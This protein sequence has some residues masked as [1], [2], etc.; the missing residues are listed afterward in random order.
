MVWHIFRKDWKLLWIFVVAVALLHWISAVIRFKLGFFNEDEFLEM[1]SRYLPSLAVFGS[2]FL[3]AA[4]VHL[5]AIPGA[6]QDWLTRPIPR[7]SLL[8]EKLLFVVIMV[9]GPIFAANLAQGLA[10]GFSWRSSLLSTAWYVAFLFFFIILPILSFASVTRNMTEAFILACGCTLIIATFLTL[11]GSMNYSAHGT[12]ISVTHSGVGWIGEVFRFALISVAACVILGVQYLRRKTVWARFFVVLF[13]SLLL[14]STYLPWGPV[15]AIEERLSPRPG[16]GVG[17]E[18]TFNQAQ[19]RFKSPSGLLVSA[20]NGQRRG[21]EHAAEVFLPLQVAGVRNDAILLVDRVEMYLSGQDGRALYHGTGEPFEVAREGPN[22]REE[23]VYQ[24][25]EIPR[26]VYRSARDQA[27]QARA[28]YSVTLFGLRRS[29]SLPAL[30]G[31]E[32]MPAWGRCETKMDEAGTNVE[33]RCMEPGKG[34]ICGTA[35]LENASSGAQNPPR[36]F[37]ESEY[38]P[39]G[40]RPLPDNFARFGINLPF[41]DPS[42]L[43]KFPVDGSQ[44]PQS[45]VVIR[46]YEP[47]DHFTRSLLIPQIKLGDWEAQ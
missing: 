36:S 23:P 20:A 24:Q 27:V 9:E 46:V 41:R 31:D 43:A 26:L 34:P 7:R 28:D 5:E 11:S 15:Y 21:D 6:R 14:V 3:I 37:C 32:R 35:F 1:L 17:T 4:I 18:L 16:A 19:G 40:D 45:R 22:P 8:L 44:L 25:I 12:L 33:L 2:M 42:G 10:N 30:D 38:R 13:G 47:E 29:Y 39:F